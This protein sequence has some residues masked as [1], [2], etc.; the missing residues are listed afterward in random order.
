M[1]IVPECDTQFVNGT[2]FC[3]MYSQQLAPSL[4][5][6][7]VFKDKSSIAG[8][9]TSSLAPIH[10]NGGPQGLIDGVLDSFWAYVNTYIM[11]VIVTDFVS[12]ITMDFNVYWNF[13]ST[14]F[15]FIIFQVIGCVGGG[16]RYWSMAADTW[17]LA[18]LGR[19]DAL[20]IFFIL[21]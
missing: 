2:W 3:E 10:T 4:V 18:F 1:R 16:R 8:M 21:E 7:A 20:F 5:V 19:L 12:T 6:A 15:D 9:F 14:D 17:L 11:S 13:F